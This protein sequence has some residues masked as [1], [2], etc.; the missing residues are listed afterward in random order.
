[1]GFGLDDWI[2]SP[3]AF[4]TRDYRQYSAIADLQYLQ[5]TIPHGLGFSVF[6]SRILATHLKQS[7]SNFISHRKSPL[8]NQ[9][10]F[11]SV[12]LPTAPLELGTQL[13]TRLESS[14]RSS[15]SFITPRHG[16]RRKHNLNYY[17]CVYRAL[18]SNGRLADHIENIDLLLS[19]CM[20]CA[21]PS[22]GSTRHNILSRELVTING[23]RIGNWIY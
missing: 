20:L 1:M 9:I 11:C 19:A 18:H 2:F 6:N 4:T 13:S 14:G 21:L 10:H 22:S 12:I 5:L 15:L 3:C 23:F 16:P 17:S 7:H 8:Q